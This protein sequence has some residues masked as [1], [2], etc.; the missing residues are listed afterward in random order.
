M[1]RTTAGQV[2]SRCGR[3]PLA[4]KEGLH[5]E[6][7]VAPGLQLH[8]LMGTKC[9]REWSIFARDERLFGNCSQQRIRSC[10]SLFDLKKPWQKE[11]TTWSS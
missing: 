3:G 1:P 11:F 8:K 5:Q 4:C 6:A 10:S 7:Y 9:E 2:D